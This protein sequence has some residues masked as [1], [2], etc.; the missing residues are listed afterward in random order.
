MRGSPLL[1]LFLLAGAL[2]LLAVPVWR[3][4]IHSTP[5]QEIPA[6][7]TE[8]S[9]DLADYR[10]FLTA[11]SPAR[12]QAMAANRS[13]AASSGATQKFEAVFSMSADEPEDIAVFADYTERTQPAALRVEVQRSG[14][15]LVEKTFWGTGVVEDVVTIPA[16]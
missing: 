11:S 16:K 4:T 9:E 5:E 13:T 1:R 7:P 12:L 2:A 3:L 14:Q 8:P 6:K 15:V 10:V